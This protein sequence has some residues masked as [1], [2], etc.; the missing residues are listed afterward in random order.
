MIPYIPQINKQ[1]PIQEYRINDWI[2]YNDSTTARPIL[3]SVTTIN[4]ISKDI[5]V[6]WNTGQ[7]IAYNEEWLDKYCRRI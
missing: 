1:N 3:G 6:K 2:R 4:N 7:I 5:I